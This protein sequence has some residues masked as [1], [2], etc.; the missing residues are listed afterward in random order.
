MMVAFD[1]SVSGERFERPVIDLSWRRSR[2][3]QADGADGDAAH[4]WASPLPDVS[5]TIPTWAIGIEISEQAQRAWTLDLLSLVVCPARKAAVERMERAEGYVMSLLN[6]DADL[7]EVALSS[8]VG[9]VVTVASLDAAAASGITQSLAGLAVAQ[10]DQSVAITTIITDLAGAMAIE[11]RA[12]RPQSSDNLNGVSQR[13]D[14][15]FRVLNA[16]WPTGWR[17]TSRTTRR[18]LPRRW[19]VRQALRHPPRQSL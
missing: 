6:G 18:G 10:P 12:G 15:K 13:L 11:Q 3:F 16:Q 1:D 9:K 5:R 14:T 8:I 7:G 4:R 17:S 19:S 2:P